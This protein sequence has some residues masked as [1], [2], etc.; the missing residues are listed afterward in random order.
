MVVFILML[1]TGI[2]HA[3]TTAPVSRV[4]FS[5]T[6]GQSRIGMTLLVNSSGAV[7]GGHYFYAKDLK[8]IPLTA[9]TQGTGMILYGAEGGQFSLRFK[10]NGSEAGEPLGFQNSI[11][12]EGRWMK[13]A[14]SYPV[15]LHTEHVTQGPAH[16]R[17]YEDVTPESDAAFEAEVQA[18][19]KAVLSG[20]RAAAAHYVKFPLRVN[21]AGKNHIVHS[22]AEL[23]AQWKQIFTPACMDAFRKA[24]P[25]DM[26][27]RN[28]EAMLGDG[29]VWFGPKGAQTI[30]VPK[31]P[32]DF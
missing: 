9:G 21:K 6:M 27:V 20:D 16:A 19:Y 30:N 7:T 11:G 24:I 18:F 23:S 22:A 32:D 12:M 3:Q 4:T 1:V 5:G 25:H 31:L 10:G 26:F 14:S 2:A 8:D 29:L 13:G 28:G 15:V 17:W